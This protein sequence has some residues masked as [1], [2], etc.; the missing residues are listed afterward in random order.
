MGQESKAAGWRATHRV[1]VVSRSPHS[2]QVFNVMLRKDG[3]APTQFEWSNGLAPM[4]GRRRGATGE[5]DDW[6]VADGQRLG[7]NVSRLI[8]KP[9]DSTARHA[10]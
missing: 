10:A 2:I 6:F 3:T 7:I 4:F 8:V 9:A 1:M 5:A